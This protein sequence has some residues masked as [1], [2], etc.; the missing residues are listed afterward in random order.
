MQ[1]IILI[2]IE[3]RWDGEAG[4][5]HHRLFSDYIDGIWKAGGYPMLVPVTPDK[6]QMEGLVNMAD[7]L[8]LSG[9][10]DVAPWRYGE[11]N[12][13][14]CGELNEERDELEFLLLDAFVQKKKP[15]LGICRGMQVIN[16]YFGGKLWQ[17]LPSQCGVY[18]R[19]THH[20]IVC[21]EDSVLEKLFGREFEVNSFHHQAV[22]KLGTDLSAIAYNEKV[23]EAFKHNTLPILGLQFHPERMLTEDS[24]FGGPDMQRLFN[25][26]IEN[27]V[28][29]IRSI[30]IG[31]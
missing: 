24:A 10:I 1:P 9:G 12:N 26:F 6:E 18:H 19:D 2:P 11:D 4:Y 15:V 25:Y 30:V 29:A 27:Y 13:G 22:R 23:I 31:K 3:R 8:L 17:D 7:G 16:C 5:F 28:G 14:L 20:Q 21:S